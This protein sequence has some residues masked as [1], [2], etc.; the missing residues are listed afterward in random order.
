[1]FAQNVT[2]IMIMRKIWS[3]LR[4]P[5]TSRW[6]PAARRVAPIRPSLQDRLPEIPPLRHRCGC[7]N[8]REKGLDK[9]RRTQA[10]RSRPAQWTASAHRQSQS[11]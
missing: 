11:A 10:D 7:R 2:N 4:P 5:V 9:E 6:H 8:D 3:G 1:M